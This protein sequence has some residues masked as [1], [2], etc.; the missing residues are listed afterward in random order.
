MPLVSP[1]LCLCEGC[2]AFP[3]TS[4]PQV[5][6]VTPPHF[7]LRTPDLPHTGSGG[8]PRQLPAQTPI[9]PRQQPGS[10]APAR[11]RIHSSP[12]FSPFPVSND[13]QE[14]PWVHKGGIGGGCELSPPFAAAAGTAR[15]LWHYRSAQSTRS[16]GQV[17]ALSP[18]A[19]QGSSGRK[20]AAGQGRGYLHPSPAGNH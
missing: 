14:D 11:C 2:D 13:G 1:P 3:S 15:L 9:T 16:R 18:P 8:D 12:H 20:R 5:G 10:S 17:A 7:T 6:T 19:S 4:A